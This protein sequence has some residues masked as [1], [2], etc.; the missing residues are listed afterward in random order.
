[1]SWLLSF[2]HRILLQ[3]QQKAA[4]AGYNRFHFIQVHSFHMI[5]EYSHPWKQPVLD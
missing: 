1:M 5:F 3:F 2:T 4:A